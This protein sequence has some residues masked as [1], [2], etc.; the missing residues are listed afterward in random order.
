MAQAATGR[1]PRPAKLKLIE[2]R[3]PGRDSGGREVRKPPSFVRLPP[4]PPA[5]LGDVARSEWERVVPELQRLQLCKP[6]DAAALGA[7]CEMV[8]LFVR[9]TD[10][11]HRS[12]LTVENRSVKKNGDTSVWYTANP[13]VGVQRNAQQAIRAWCSEFGLTPAAELKVSGSAAKEA[14]DGPN[15]FAG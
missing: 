1:K 14:D 5:W 7:Y 6:V 2:G 8:E 9:A 13:A 15:P 10:E 3:S 12:G 4:E 11:V